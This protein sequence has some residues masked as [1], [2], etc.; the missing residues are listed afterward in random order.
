MWPLFVAGAALQ[1]LGQYSANQAQ[2]Q[3]EEANANY[4]DAQAEYAAAS[5]RRELKLAKTS[6]TQQISKQ[7]GIIAANGIDLTRGSAA[8]IVANSQASALDQLNAIE[9]KGYMERS[10]ASARANRSRDLSQTLGSLEYNLPQI[11]GTILTSAASY[12]NTE[13]NRNRGAI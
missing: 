11:G 7:E 3:A 5:T 6:F 1:I 9:Y 12:V 4:Y 2:S 8:S 13:A 10:L